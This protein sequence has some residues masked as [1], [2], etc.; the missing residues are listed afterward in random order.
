MDG[1]GQQGKGRSSLFAGGVADWR[2]VLFVRLHRKGYRELPMQLTCDALGD[3]WQ[4]KL[5]LRQLEI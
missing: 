1:L 3:D 5:P 2:W 4:V